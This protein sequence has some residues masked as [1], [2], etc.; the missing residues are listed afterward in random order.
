MMAVQIHREIAMV[1]QLRLM[2]KMAPLLPTKMRSYSRLQ[3]LHAKRLHDIVIATDGES[4][5]PI[6]FIGARA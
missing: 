4:L 3:F 6:R 2:I 1:Q 5:D